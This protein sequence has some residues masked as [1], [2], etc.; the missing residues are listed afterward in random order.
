MQSNAFVHLLAM[1]KYEDLDPKQRAA[2]LAF[3]YDSELQNG[4]HLQFFLNRRH[5]IHDTGGALRSLGGFEQADIFD[6]AFAIWRSRSRVPPVTADEYVAVALEGEF[7]V[8]DREFYRCSVSITEL[9][10]RHLAGHESNFVIRGDSGHLFMAAIRA[11]K[12]WG[13]AMLSLV[14]RNRRAP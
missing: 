2:H 5:R 10:E 1:T 12:G 7:D 3:W 13:S 11:A 6:R 9:L 14:T 8:L 4:G